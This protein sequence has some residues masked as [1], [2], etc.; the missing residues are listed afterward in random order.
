[1]IRKSLSVIIN[2]SLVTGI[3]PN[4]LRLSKVIPLYKKGDKQYL[5]IVDRYL[6]YP[7]ATISKVFERVLYNQIYDH[8]TSIHYYVKSNMV[9]DQNIQQNLLE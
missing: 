6:C 9:S 3:F 5:N 7:L 8:F 1:M 4:A 2:K